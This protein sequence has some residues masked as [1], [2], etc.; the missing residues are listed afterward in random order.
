[1]KRL[2]AAGYPRLFQICKFFRDSEVSPLHNPEFTGLEWYSVG[3][4]Y[5]VLMDLTEA[6]ICDLWQDRPLSYQG[7]TIDLSTPWERISCSEAIA[8]HVP[9]SIP[10]HPDTAQ[11]ADACRTLGLSVDSHDAWED[12]YFKIFLTHVEP[13][14]GKT[15]PTFLYDYP[16]QMAALSRAK[17]S[18]PLLAE[19]VELYI[20]GL[21]I[22]NGYSEL[23]DPTI[24]RQRWREEA[25]IRQQ[26][27]ESHPYPPDPGLLNALEWGMP[28]CAGIAVGID[29][30]LMLYL[31]TTHIDDVLP[32]PISST[33]WPP[34]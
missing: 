21:E 27:G 20:A 28:P 7:Q 22:A 6:M 9:V 29:R 2:V 8:R 33:M 18:N 31:D 10:A 25:D 4:D 34:S 23:N 12:L 13:H 5:H 3:H 17:P 19:R 32:F 14:L 15:Q 30:L 11:L 16:I 1:M 26:N 24:Q